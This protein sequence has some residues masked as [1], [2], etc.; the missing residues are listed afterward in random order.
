MV[1][2]IKKYKTFASLHTYGNK[3]T[4]LVLFIFPILLPFVHTTV[5]MYII[6]AVVSISAIEELIIQLTS[7]QLQLNKQSIFENR[8]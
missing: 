1:I 7:S 8:T 2:G 6:C 5:L 4:G 3:I